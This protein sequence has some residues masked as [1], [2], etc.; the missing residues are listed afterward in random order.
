MKDAGVCM[1]FLGF[2]FGKRIMEDCWLWTR[3]C[4]THLVVWLNGFLPEV[5][6]VAV[7]ARSEDH[8]FNPM[9]VC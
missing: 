7:E 6:V 1:P 9:L 5:K 4:L 3:V 2:L 8:L